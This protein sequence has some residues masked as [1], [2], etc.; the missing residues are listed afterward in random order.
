MA[1]FLT[2]QEV[3]SVCQRPILL[4]VGSLQLPLCRAG[5]GG[6]LILP[7]LSAVGE[8]RVSLLGPKTA[9]TSN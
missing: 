6:L 8:K 5:K 9:S 4:K 2:K 3:L 1:D 7:Y